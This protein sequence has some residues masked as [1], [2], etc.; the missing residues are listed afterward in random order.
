[1]RAR[2]RAQACTG[3]ACKCLAITTERVSNNRLLPLAPPRVLRQPFVA[4]TQHSCMLA[5]IPGRPHA[6]IHALSC[7]ASMGACA[8]GP[9][10]LPCALRPR[11]IQS[12]SP[13]YCPAL[14]APLTQACGMIPH[15][16]CRGRPYLPAR[17]TLPWALRLKP[18]QFTSPWGNACKTCT[19][20]DPT[21]TLPGGH[22]SPRVQ[23][24]TPSN[25]PAFVMT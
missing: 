20:L 4:A 6:I 19:S 17:C 1:M 13:G 22:G 16:P 12:S 21:H 24:A 8:L 11:A 23:C 2:A 5:C 7:E 15:T 3:H 18:V 9:S 10:T 25:L 14:V